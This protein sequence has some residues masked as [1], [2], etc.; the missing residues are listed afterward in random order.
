[1]GSRPDPVAESRNQA[2]LVLAAERLH[3]ARGWLT[4]G[5]TQGALLLSAVLAVYEAGARLDLAAVFGAFSFLL[6]GVL[7]GYRSRRAD[8]FES[9]TAGIVLAL[10]LG[11]VVIWVL[12]HAIGPVGLLAVVTGGVIFAASG[13]ALGLRLRT[14]TVEHAHG[15]GRPSWPWIVVGAVLGIVLNIIGALVLDSVASPSQTVLATSFAASFLVGGAFVGY[16]SPGQTLWDPATTG[17][18][19]LGFEWLLLLAVFGVW[20]P[21]AAVLAGAGAGFA[22]VLAGGW[23]GIQARR[24][25]AA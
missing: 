2:R 25:W 21:L 18:L 22:L 6:I 24:I 16:H 13:G 14:T 11:V 23:L 12:G 1:M 10:G 8:L 19:V 20:F 17:L 4:V 5:L 3:A 7:L 15:D 9:L